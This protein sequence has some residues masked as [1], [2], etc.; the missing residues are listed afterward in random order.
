MIIIGKIVAIPT[1]LGGRENP[2]YD[3]YR[4]RF[5]LYD[6]SRQD[7]SDCSLMVINGSKIEPGKSGEVKITI[8]NPKNFNG[9][10]FGKRFY[11]AEGLRIVA[12]GTIVNI[13]E[14]DS[15]FKWISEI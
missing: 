6:Y 5:W 2:I 3:Y 11:L 4:P 12:K 9:F 13:N 10:I 8:L 1:D 14:F 7:S 15:N